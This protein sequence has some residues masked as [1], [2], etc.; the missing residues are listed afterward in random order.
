MCANKQDIENYTV[1]SDPLVSIVAEPNLHGRRNHVYGKPQNVRFAFL[2]SR[3]NEY[4]MDENGA[5]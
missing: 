3:K 2:F 4:Y 1:P 5:K